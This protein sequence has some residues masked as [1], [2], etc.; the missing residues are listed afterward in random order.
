MNATKELI[1]IVCPR[2]CRLQVD[3]DLNV[4]G[5]GCPRGVVYGKAELLNPTRLLSSTVAI[6]SAHFARLPVVTNKEIPKGRIFEVMAAI[7]KVRV[8]APVRLHQTII[9]DVLGLGIDVIATRTIPE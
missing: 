4:S 5:Q 3:D 6:Q 1:C 7:K 8:H 2:G 9:S